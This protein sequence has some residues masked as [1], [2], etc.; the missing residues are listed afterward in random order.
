MNAQANLTFSSIG[1][2][3]LWRTVSPALVS[4]LHSPSVSCPI[5]FLPPAR[6]PWG[7]R[8]C[9]GPVSIIWER[10]AAEGPL[11]AMMIPCLP[12]PFFKRIHI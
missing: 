12:P 4:E 6:E 8:R 2:P 9:R 1:P 10:D 3:C 11:D 7:Y 5:F